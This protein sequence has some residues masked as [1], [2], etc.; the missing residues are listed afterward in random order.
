MI[1]RKSYTANEKRAAIKHAEVY[2]T[3]SAANKFEVN[4]RMIQ[5][6]VQMKE[7]LENCDR[8]KRAFR[9]KPAQYP[10]VEEKIKAWEES[11]TKAAA[12]HPN[13]VASS[14]WCQNFL[15]RNDLSLRRRTSVGQPLPENHLEKIRS[16]RNFVMEETRNIAP[17][18][19][20]NFDEVPV[21][22]DIV[23]ERTVHAKGDDCVKIDTTGHEKSNFTVVLGVTASGEK[24]KPMI[25]FK[26]KLLPKGNFPPNVV[27]KVND[28]GW[29]TEDIMKEWIEEVWKERL[30]YNPDSRN[31]LLIFDS[32]RS[33]LTEG[34]REALQ[35]SSKIAV[36][37]GGL[38]RF[39]QPLDVSVNKP[40]KDGLRQRW[41]DWMEDK[42]NAEYTKGGRRKRCSYEKAA[43][44]VSDSFNA[45]SSDTIING[46]NKALVN[47]PDEETEKY[48]H[49]FEAMEIDE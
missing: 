41:E 47:I 37:P 19:I 42:E 29:M 26:K 5:K 21:P 45:L 22:F 17:C 13:F 35:Q 43:W 7:K 34:V 4:Q 2:G 18:N 48:I 44:I 40:F 30:H 25:I 8:N 16:F 36:I 38:T 33:H 11:C 23:Y 31:S 1:K 39:L 3:A 49:N 20:G 27:I 32:A 24:L 6:W 46:F 10:D 9:G 15:R 28:K 14:Q 12:N